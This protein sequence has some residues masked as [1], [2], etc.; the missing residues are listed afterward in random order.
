MHYIAIFEQ[1]DRLELALSLLEATGIPAPDIALASL[2]GKAA[3]IKDIYLP[4]QL[5]LLSPYETM[6]VLAA[7]TST[8]GAVYGYS[9]TWGPII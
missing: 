7:F 3:G 1:T 9:L 6:A 5:Y 4:G 2:R 8:L